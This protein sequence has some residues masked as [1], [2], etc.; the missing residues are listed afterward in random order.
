MVDWI[1]LFTKY[2]ITCVNEEYTIDGITYPKEVTHY[3]ERATVNVFP[4]DPNPIEAELI[5]AFQKAILK[6]LKVVKK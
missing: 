4:H 6:N 1:T 2:G 5:I 3:L